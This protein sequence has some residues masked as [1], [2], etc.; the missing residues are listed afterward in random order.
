VLS[1][2]IY[3]QY[4]KPETAM[5]QIGRIFKEADHYDN[6]LVNNFGAIW[7]DKEED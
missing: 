7:K 1:T 2:A 3:S 5:K 4:L 6:V